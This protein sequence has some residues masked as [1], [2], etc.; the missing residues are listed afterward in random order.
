[1]LRHDKRERFRFAPLQSRFAESVLNRHGTTSSVN[2]TV[3]VVNDPGQNEQL[4]LRSEGALF[5]LKELGG[6]WRLLSGLSRVFPL[7]LRDA[8]YNWIARHRSQVFGRHERCPLPSAEV[9]QR[10]LD[11]P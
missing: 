7:W 1:V 10:F 2:Q 9:R 3:Y 5:V 4:L 6:A 8:V 11:L